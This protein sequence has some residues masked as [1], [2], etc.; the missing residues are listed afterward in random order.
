M[1]VHIYPSA[2]IDTP[3]TTHMEKMNC[4]FLHCL[5]KH[6]SGCLLPLFLDAVTATGNNRAI[7]GMLLGRAGAGA[8]I[9]ILQLTP[10]PPSQRVEEEVSNL[11]LL[12]LFYAQLNSTPILGRKRIAK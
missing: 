12:L 1:P 2:K 5:A 10:P 9:I 11:F 3:L 6:P 4:W 8:T 7:Q